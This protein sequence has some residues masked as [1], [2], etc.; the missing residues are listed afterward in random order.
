MNKH[1]ETSIKNKP[2][3]L[4]PNVEAALSYLIPPFSGIAIYMMEK[5]NKFI[6][7]HSLQSVLF[8]VAA[9]ILM[10]IANMMVVIFIGIILA[11]LLSLALF[12]AWMYVMWR[13]YNN[14]E[15]MLPIIGQMAKDHLAKEK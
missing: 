12:A 6:R 11:P 1:S 3:D 8:G 2:Y 10:T 13:A 15:Y 5:D 14:E 7:F 4:E 9:F